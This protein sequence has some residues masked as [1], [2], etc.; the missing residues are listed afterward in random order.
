MVRRAGVAWG[1]GFLGLG[2]VRQAPLR[3]TRPLLRRFSMRTDPTGERVKERPKVK[4]GE[5]VKEQ[6]RFF[7]IYVYL[8]G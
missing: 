8:P 2:R 4:K 3:S 1:R 5:R 6:N 7:P